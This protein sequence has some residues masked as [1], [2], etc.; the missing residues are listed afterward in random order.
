MDPNRS[1]VIQTRNQ[2]QTGSKSDP[3]HARDLILDLVFQPPHQTHPK[4]S[5]TSTRPPLLNCVIFTSLLSPSPP[6]HKSSHQLVHHTACPPQVQMSICAG[7]CW[8]HVCA[9]KQVWILWWK[10]VRNVGFR[11]NSDAILWQKSVRTVFGTEFAMLG[12]IWGENEL[13][14]VVFSLAAVTVLSCKC[15]AVA[16]SL[17]FAA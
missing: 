5:E 12:V 9:T 15:C 4:P 14:W 16:A 6:H 10:S 8:V 7:F 3:T 2:I 1:K 13:S 11:T 17:D